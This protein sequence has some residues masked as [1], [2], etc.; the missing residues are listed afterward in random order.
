MAFRESRRPKAVAQA[1]MDRSSFYAGPESLLAIGCFLRG[2]NRSHI[3]RDPFDPA[4][5]CNS[6]DSR[7]RVALSASGK[8]RHLQTS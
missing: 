4:D 8:E 6:K 3:H 7:P 2:I 5:A 1:L